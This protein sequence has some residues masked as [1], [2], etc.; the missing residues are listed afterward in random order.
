MGD[1]AVI[2]TGTAL[3]KVTKDGQLILLSTAISG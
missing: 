2:L 1:G 3:G